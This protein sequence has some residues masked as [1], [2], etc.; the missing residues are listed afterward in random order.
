MAGNNFFVK[1]AAVAGVVPMAKVITVVAVKTRKV[2][3]GYSLT[4]VAQT[5][6]MTLR[7]LAHLFFAH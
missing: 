6:M 2:K 7:K 1:E 5:T 4:L 3:A